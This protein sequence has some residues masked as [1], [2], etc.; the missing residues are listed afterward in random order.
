MEAGKHMV[1][2]VC[3][4]RDNLISDISVIGILMM[5]LW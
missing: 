3:Y 1:M 5:Q 4:G 2:M